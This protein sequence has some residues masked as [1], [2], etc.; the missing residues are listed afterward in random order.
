MYVTL[1]SCYSA[2]MSVLGQGCKVCPYSDIEMMK[3]EHVSASRKDLRVRLLH[4]Q[5]NH[6]AL[7]S[8]TRDVFQKTAAFISAL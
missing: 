1:S 7:A 6:L 8:P 5:D 3:S 4:D 2:P